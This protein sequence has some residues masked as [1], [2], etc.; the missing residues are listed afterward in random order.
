M[1]E[2]A[3]GHV[4]ACINFVMVRS[5]GGLLSIHS[6][7]ERILRGIRN[8]MIVDGTYVVGESG[9][10]IPMR[11]GFDDVAACF[12]ECS[13]DNARAETTAETNSV[14]GLTIPP[15]GGPSGTR[16][17]PEVEVKYTG[18]L[19]NMMTRRRPCHQPTPT[20]CRI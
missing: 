13:V 9:P 16:T 12:A 20:R 2:L 5:R 6:R 10:C 8:Q 14:G 17:R 3:R 4:E 18:C 11:D 19:L 7:C 1:G 15:T